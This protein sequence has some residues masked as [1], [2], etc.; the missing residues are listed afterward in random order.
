MKAVFTPPLGGQVEVAQQATPSA[1]TWNTCRCPA[2][3]Y[4]GSA[5]SSRRV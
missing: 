2:A 4:I 5:I 3:V 1:S